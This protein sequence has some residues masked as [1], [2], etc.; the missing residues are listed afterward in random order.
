MNGQIEK[1]ERRDLVKKGLLFGLGAFFINGFKSTSVRANNTFIDEINSKTTSLIYPFTL[2]KLE[3]GFDALEPNIDKMTMEI[4]YSKHHQGYLNNLNKILETNKGLQNIKIE[5]V[6]TKI[7]NEKSDSGLRNNAGGHF[8]H[9]FFW[10]ILTPKQNINEPKGDLLVHIL[11]DF[12]TY[13]R[14]KVSFE[15]AAKSRFGSGW[16]WLVYDANDRKLKITSTPNQDNPLMTFSEVKGEPII[17]I[18]VWEHA[19]YLKYQNKRAD[20]ITAFWNVVDWTKAEN[21]YN[22]A[23]LK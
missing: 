14:F 18:D 22:K 17:G 10:N 8:N 23:T 20:Y 3:Y 6:L 4:H 11:R 2:P 13:D 5:E 16:A 12:G 21:N 19:Y 1:L 15:D 9:T 7:T